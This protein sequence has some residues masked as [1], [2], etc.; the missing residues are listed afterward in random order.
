M[1]IAGS[2]WS[3]QHKDWSLCTL[4]STLETDFLN[5][6]LFDDSM[7]GAC[8]LVYNQHNICIKLV[9]DAALIASTLSQF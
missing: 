4:S 8:V 1:Y 3:Q 6:H 2:Q 5:A 7:N 9:T